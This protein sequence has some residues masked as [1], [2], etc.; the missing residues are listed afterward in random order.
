MNEKALRP[1]ELQTKFLIGG[2]PRFSLITRDGNLDGKNMKSIGDQLNAGLKPA[3]QRNCSISQA[4]TPR[5]LNEKN[6]QI[7]IIVTKE[8]LDLNPN[9][10]T[11]LFN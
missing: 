8:R 1:L 4:K 5:N 7:L 3:N 11:D 9:V 2:S 6:I 10:S